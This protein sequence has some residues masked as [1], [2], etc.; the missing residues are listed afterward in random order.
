[1]RPLSAHGLDLGGPPETWKLSHTVLARAMESGLAAV[2][3][4]HL[5]LPT[6]LRV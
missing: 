6:I 2:S 5:T 1:M 4:T 3:Y